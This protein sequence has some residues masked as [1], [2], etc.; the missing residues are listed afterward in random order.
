MFSTHLRHFI[1]K[2][3]RINVNSSILI[4][5]KS[6]LIA[7]FNGVDT[8]YQV[9]VVKTLSTA[10]VQLANSVRNKHDIRIQ[11]TDSFCI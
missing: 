4:Y 11:A 1:G 6:S 2:I 5:K 8:F 9:P 3:D 10:L 7:L